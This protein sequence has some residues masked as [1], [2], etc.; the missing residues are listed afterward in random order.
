MQD[1]KADDEKWG[2][3]ER[4]EEGE[5][6]GG[7]GCLQGKDCPTCRPGFAKFGEFEICDRARQ[8]RRMSANTI[9][10]DGRLVRADIGRVSL[11]WT[12]T[13]TG[14]CNS[15]RGRRGGGGEGIVFCREVLLGSAT[16]KRQRRARNV[17]AAAVR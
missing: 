3:M 16:H 17:N 5:G 2:A 12:C 8:R 13:S 11:H 1:R 9:V 4:S 15:R 14:I 7:C 6:A 10:R